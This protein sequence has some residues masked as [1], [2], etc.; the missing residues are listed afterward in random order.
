M[1]SDGSTLTVAGALTLSGA[2]SMSTT[3]AVTGVISPTTHIDMPDSA[4][5]KLGTG[6]DMQLYHDG[7]NSYITNS[8]GALKIA[9]ETSGIAITIGHGTSEVTVAD[10]LTV[11]GD[12][13]VSGDTVTMNTA[14]LTVEDSLIKLA[15][16][17]TGSAYDQGIVFTR[18]NGSSSNTQNMAFIWDESAD[19][20]ATIQSSTEDGTTAGNMTVTDHVDLRVGALTADDSSTFTSGFVV[21]SDGSGADVIFYS[22]TSGDNMTWDASEECL[23]I[24]GTD[25]Q[26]A[27]KIADGDLV[28]VDKLYIY[29]NDGGEYISGDGSTATLTGAWA[30]ANMTITGG[31]ISGITDLAV[32][33]GGTGASTLTDGGILLGSGTGAITAMSVLGDGVIVVGDNSTD[34]TTITAFTAN[35]GYLKHE[36]G[37]IEADISSIAKGGLV[38]GTGTGSMGVKAVGTNDY[39]LTADSSATGGVKWAENSAATKGFAVAMAVAL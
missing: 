25:G 18:G 3:L 29:D 23:T 1:S 7:S 22:G 14:T 27:L 20:F 35:D 32:A 24:T 19:T 9:T 34:P 38:V 21:G 8:T 33:D 13:T 2:V 26:Q 4:N 17:Y 15:Q 11:T 28:V 39:L 5:I 16:G 10:N 37:G 30:S 12:L 31:A 36:V 6:D